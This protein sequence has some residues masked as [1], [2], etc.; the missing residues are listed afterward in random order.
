MT[1]IKCNNLRETNNLHD[2]LHIRPLFISD[3]S[4]QQT[5]QPQAALA[6]K[7]GNPGD[8]STEFQ[9][10]GKYRQAGCFKDTET[11]AVPLLEGKIAQIPHHTIP[12]HT[13]PY[14]TIPYHAMTVV[15]PH[16]IVLHHTTPHHTTNTTYYTTF[17]TGSDIQLTGF[18]KQRQDPIA[19]CAAV[20]KSYGFQLF[21]IQNGGMCL[22][23]PNAHDTYKI[24]GLAK[25]CKDG[26]GGPWASDV[27]I[28]NGK[29]F[30]VK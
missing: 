9:G 8:S 23:G 7:S 19:K 26:K 6:Q 13:I 14:H 18:Y 20:A 15:Y 3:N 29:T 22:S 24:H 4:R 2:N 30:F 16:H 10:T 27:Y 17:L 21:A 5:S 1:P 12:Y 25:N 28:F 11:R